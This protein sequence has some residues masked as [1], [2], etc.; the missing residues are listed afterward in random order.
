MPLRVTDV[1]GAAGAGELEQAFKTCLDEMDKCER[2]ECYWA[3]LH[4][5][6]VL[7]DICAA[8]EHDKGDTSGEIGRCYESWCERYWC[9]ATISARRRWEIRCAL[10]HQGRTV[11]KDG[12]TFSYIRPAPSGSKVH[13]YV[14]PDEPNTTLEVHKLAAEVKRAIRAWFRDLTQPE[15][16]SKLENVLRHLPKL[17]REKPKV[18]PGILE[19]PGNVSSTE[20]DTTAPSATG[21]P[22]A[23]SRESKRSS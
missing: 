19:N 3:L 12:E 9:S 13:E 21:S 7:P 11:L 5:V 22:S 20:F 23:R 14:H 17:A 10:L 8:L 16:A 15:R 2:A 4:M 1:K 18:L 6:V